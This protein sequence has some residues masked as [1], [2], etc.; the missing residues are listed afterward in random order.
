LLLTRI[1]PMIGKP[2]QETFGAKIIEYFG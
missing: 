1:N 2:N